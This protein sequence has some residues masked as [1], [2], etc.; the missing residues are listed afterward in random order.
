MSTSP[1]GPVWCDNQSSIAQ[2]LA[3]S[4]FKLRTRHVSIEAHR[5]GE[6]IQHGIVDL[7]CIQ[8]E[9]QKADCLTKAYT[10]PLMLRCCEHLSL[11]SIYGQDDT[12]Q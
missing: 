3:G 9:D 1:C 7:A 2:T 8:L 11:V 4:A 6:D 5:L 12:K 10:K